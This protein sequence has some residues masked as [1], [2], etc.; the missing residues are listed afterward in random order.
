MHCFLPPFYFTVA[1]VVFSQDGLRSSQVQG[2]HTIGSIIS[3]HIKPVWILCMYFMLLHPALNHIYSWLR[4]TWLELLLF[5]ITTFVHTLTF[6]FFCVSPL[7]SNFGGIFCFV[8]TFGSQTIL[9]LLRSLYIID[10]EPRGLPFC[11]ILEENYHSCWAKLV[12]SLMLSI[13]ALAIIIRHLKNV[14]HVT[15]WLEAM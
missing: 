7:F 12:P 2:K 14:Y 9:K 10:T 11:P 15:K 8:Y 1:V 13:L 3:N 4:K 6:I 5:D